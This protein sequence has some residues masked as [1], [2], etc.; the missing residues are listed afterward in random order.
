MDTHESKL[1]NIH[2]NKWLLQGIKAHHVNLNKS[3]HS[4]HLCSIS[5]VNE[6]LHVTFGDTREHF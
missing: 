4:I 5:D 6:K 3:S 2:E 1:N